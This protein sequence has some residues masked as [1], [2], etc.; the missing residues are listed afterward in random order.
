[1]INQE[2]LLALIEF[3][4]AADPG[5][6]LVAILVL[7]IGIGFAWA[8]SKVCHHK[9][10]GMFPRSSPAGRVLI[11]RFLR[12]TIIVLSVIVALQVMG[13]P[14]TSLLATGTVFFV[15]FGLAIQKILQSLVAGT[16]LL[17]EREVEPG[18]VIRF[19]GEEYRVSAI[20]LRTTQLE[21]RFCETL[22]LP[23]YILATSPVLNLTHRESSVE[24]RLEVQVAYGCDSDAVEQ[25]LLRAT[26]KVDDRT[27]TQAHAI[28]L[29]FGDSGVNWLVK[30]GI[31]DPWPLPLRKSQLARQV[32]KEFERAELEIPFPQ[33]DLHLRSG[34]PA[35]DHAPSL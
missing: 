28:L 32:I 22:I 6:F 1:M 15:G 11:S 16:L 19:D 26:E 34:Q 7:L 5:H 18:D 25:A 21:N 24:V 29:S 35:A 30:A 10:L 9:L 8:L 33:R 17:L 12:L 2:S 27:A 13:I 14:I 23:N 31:G 20:G 3:F 4:P